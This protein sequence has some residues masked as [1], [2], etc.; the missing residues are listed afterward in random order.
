MSA[1]LER[2]FDRS[3]PEPMSGCWLWTGAATSRG[4]GKIR[5]G[6]AKDGTRST[7]QV[8][9]IVCA[10]IHGL[11]ADDDCCHKCD[12]PACVNPDH[13]FAGSRRDNML[14]AVRK[15]RVRKGA[16]HY[17]TKLSDDDAANIRDDRSASSAVIAKK[18]GVSPNHVRSIWCGFK[19]AV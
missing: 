12:V 19:R 4:Y 15:N 16:N 13:L 17:A 10:E 18:F 3:I 7:A 1:I 14:D 2:I 5:V 9:R 8:H 11:K 6:S